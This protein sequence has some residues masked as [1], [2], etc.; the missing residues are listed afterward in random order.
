MSKASN[1]KSRSFLYDWMS[2]KH[3]VALLG[4]E[5][6][7]IFSISSSMNSFMKFEWSS[8]IGVFVDQ[9]PNDINIKYYIFN[10]EC[11]GTLCCVFRVFC[12]FATHTP[13]Y[14][15]TRYHPHLDIPKEPSKDL[16]SYVGDAKVSSF[17]ILRDSC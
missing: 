12:D 6:L 3:I 13:Q 2:G 10:E 5:D 15:A 7:E 16:P 11:G 4:S 8:L 17:V 14:L 9:L 1:S